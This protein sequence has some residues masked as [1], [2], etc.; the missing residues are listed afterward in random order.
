MFNTENSTLGDATMSVW[1][2]PAHPVTVMLLAEAFNPFPGRAETEGGAIL[3][4]YEL[5]IWGDVHYTI[6]SFNMKKKEIIYIRYCTYTYS[7]F[8][9]RI[10][11]HVARMLTKFSQRCLHHIKVEQ[12]WYILCLRPSGPFCPHPQLMILLT[13]HERFVFN[14][15]LQYE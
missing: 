14:P 6:N 12:A 8:I 11:F 15:Q 1:A 4:N 5:F 2:R 9:L 10:Q 13:R 3:K 7:F